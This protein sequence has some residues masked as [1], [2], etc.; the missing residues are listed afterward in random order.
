MEVPAPRLHYG[1]L[2]EVGER[3]VHRAEPAR[4]ETDETARVARADRPVPRVDDTRQLARD[5]GLPAVAGT[6]V[7][8][9]RIRLVPARTLR[10]DENRR[11]ARTVERLLDEAHAFVRGGAGR[12]PVQ[13]VHDRIA[14]A[15]RG[16]A[17]G[18]V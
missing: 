12:Q 11:S 14:Q 1:E 9:L 17:R 7:D 16:V 18:E 15:A 5:R 2:A 4:R 13:E 8:V 10:S 6:M 3:D